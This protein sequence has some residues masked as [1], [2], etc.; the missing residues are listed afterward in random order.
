MQHE[1]FYLTCPMK[2]ENVYFQEQQGNFPRSNSSGVGN[3]V[4]GRD[5][6]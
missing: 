3:T 4:A 1:G 6:W 5:V 2:T